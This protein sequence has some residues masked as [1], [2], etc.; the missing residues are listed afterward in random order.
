VDEILEVEKPKREKPT[1]ADK[2][3]SR[4]LEAIG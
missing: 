2:Q 3:R 4:I 1:R